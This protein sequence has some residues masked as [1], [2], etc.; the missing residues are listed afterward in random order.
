MEP[1][2]DNQPHMSSEEALAIVE[3]DLGRPI[4]DVFSSFERVPM[5]AAS[6]GQVHR[7]TLR[8]DGRRVVVKVM[9]PGVSDLQIEWWSFLASGG[10]GFLCSLPL[11]LLS[12]LPLVLVLVQVE[13]V[14]R[15]DVAITKAFYSVAMPEHAGVMDEIERQFANEFDYTVEAAHL[16]RVRDNLAASGDFKDIVVPAPVLPL[17]TKRV[18]VMDEVVGAIKLTTALED[19]FKAIASA[20]GVTM[21]ALFEEEKALNAAALARGEIR[22]GPSAAEMKRIIDTIQW[23]NWW[24]RWVGAKPMHVPLNHAALIDEL[25]RVH[26]HEIFVD[27]Y[28]NGDPHPGNRESRGH[29]WWCVPEQRRAS[30]PVAQSMCVACACLQCW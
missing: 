11:P 15:G 18:L 23:R 29:C 21:E 30:I 26:G 16:K 5:A 14:F 13:R 9:Y 6:I 25:I 22:N 19:D 7:A 20:R 28:F 17:C 3:A 27:G 24:G 2:L 8:E 10:V 12:L 1:A 4:D